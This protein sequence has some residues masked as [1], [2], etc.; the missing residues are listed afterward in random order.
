MRTLYAIALI[1]LSVPAF[2]SEFDFEGLPHDSMAETGYMYDAG[3]DFS[4]DNETTAIIAS[5]TPKGEDQSIAGYLYDDGAD[6][7]FDDD[8]TGIINVPT[9][10]KDE[11]HS[12]ELGLGTDEALAYQ[13]DTVDLDAI[14]VGDWF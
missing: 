5:S 9:A 10:P 12:L 3:A 14:P 13:R 4:F 6:F 11:D 2:A 7:N 1:C 8:Y